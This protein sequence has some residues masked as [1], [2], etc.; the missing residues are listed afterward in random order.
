MRYIVRGEE[1]R[2]ENAAKP[3]SC[4]GAWLLAW[5]SQLNPHQTGLDLGC[6]KLRYTVPLARALRS[7][8]AVDSSVQLERRQMLFGAHS[9][10]REFAAKRLAN[11]RV[12]AIDEAGWARDRFGVILCSNVLSAIPSR[13]IR[14]QIVTTAYE[15]LANGG[16]LMLTT[17]YKNSH[18]AGWK[19]NPQASRYCDGFLVRTARGTSFYALLDSAALVDI[20]R[21]TGLKIVAAGHAKELAYVLAT[22]GSRDRRQSN[23]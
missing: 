22:R 4:A 3:A 9:T 12:F 1:I 14:E 21:S 17:Q 7:V 20:C 5:I 6:G 19:K 18:F 15:R 8:T 13:Q 11:V 10:I 23:K 16:E 2:S